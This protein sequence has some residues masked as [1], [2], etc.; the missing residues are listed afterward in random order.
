MAEPS[1]ED[2]LK[3]RDSGATPE[4]EEKEPRTSVEPD[5]GDDE[6]EVIRQSRKTVSDDDADDDEGATVP[7]G[8]L[9]AER[10]KRRKYTDEVADVRKALADVQ[11]QNAEMAQALLR[12]QQPQPQPQPPPEFDW[13]NPHQTIDQRVEQRI[14]Q[15][16][17]IIAAEFQRQR[18]EL[19]SNI[20]I[21]HHGEDV[22]K[23]AYQALAEARDS[24]PNW[25]QDYTRIMRSPNQ[26]E[27][28]VAWHKQRS[29]LK[30]VGSDLEAYKA[31]IRAEYLEEL[32]NGNGQTNGR[33]LVEEDELPVRRPRMPSDLSTARSVGSRSGPAF[34]EPS[35]KDI[36]ANR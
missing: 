14:T 30:E 28:M 21:S 24:D 34:V 8:A 32:R 1:A 2:I 19:Q 35:I 5:G 18:E 15:E 6:P 23:A 27:A 13:D 26:Y 31:R 36:L 22:V 4:P 11:R 16:R 29:A 7:R 20:A 25:G 10:E 9:E 3:A 12:Q 33:D 17:Q